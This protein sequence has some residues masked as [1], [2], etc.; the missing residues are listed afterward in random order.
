MK[1]LFRKIGLLPPSSKF[2]AGDQVQLKTGGDLMI[3]ECVKADRKSKTIS[4]C[5][6]WFDSKTKQHYTQL[7]HEDQLKSF[8]WYHPN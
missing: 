5:C 7:F 2:K 4:I 1:D 3:V 6:K 8:D